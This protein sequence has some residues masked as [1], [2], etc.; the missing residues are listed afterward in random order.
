M[1][2]RATLLATTFG[3][4]ALFAAPALAAP[5]TDLYD[6]ST[7]IY[8]GDGGVA[9]AGTNDFAAGHLDTN[10][11]GDPTNGSVALPCSTLTYTHS[12]AP[13]FTGPPQTLLDATLTLTFVDDETGIPDEFSA[14]WT[15]VSQSGNTGGVIKLDPDGSGVES[16]YPFDVALQLAENGQIIVTITREFAQNKNSDFSFVKSLVAANYRDGQDVVPTAP[17]PEPASMLLLGTGLAGV[18]ARV[19]RR[20]QQA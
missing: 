17:V 19:R 2:L 8:F 7:N 18:A 1:K 5:V 9:C 12:I 3:S 16:S 4:F 13:E 6:P 11:V 10:D 20:R 14:S 15:G